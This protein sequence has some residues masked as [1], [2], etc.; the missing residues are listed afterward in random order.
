LFKCGIK[1]TVHY[2][3][4]HTFSL[5]KK[6]YNQKDFPNTIKAFKECLSIPLFPT[7]TKKQQDYVLSNLQKFQN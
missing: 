7:I 3:P 2:K 5:F 1:T 6:E 4:L